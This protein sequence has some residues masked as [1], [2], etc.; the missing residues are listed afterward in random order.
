MVIFR[1]VPYKRLLS[2]VIMSIIGFMMLGVYVVVLTWCTTLGF[3]EY[4]GNRLPV[5]TREKPPDTHVE[6]LV[7][8]IQR[9]NRELQFSKSGDIDKKYF[10]TQADIRNFDNSESTKTPVNSIYLDGKSNVNTDKTDNSDTMDNTD[11]NILQP[12]HQSGNIAAIQYNNPRTFTKIRQK[13]SKKLPQALII[14]VKKGG[15]R[16]LLEFLRIHPDVRAPGPEPHFFDR[17]YDK[18]LEWYR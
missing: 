15:T 8:N 16:A 12:S 17:N 5:Y 13:M 3:P 14:G 11:K 1:Y 6:R 18:G 2:Y 9:H 10:W 7:Q 4:T